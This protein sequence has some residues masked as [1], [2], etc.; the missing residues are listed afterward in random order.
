MNSIKPVTYV[1][2]K[3]VLKWLY[4]ETRSVLWSHLKK[5]RA[6]KKNFKESLN[7]KHTL[8]NY[9][10]TKCNLMF[11]VIQIST[12]WISFLFDILAKFSNVKIISFLL[13]TFRSATDQLIGMT[14]IKLRSKRDLCSLVILDWSLGVLYFALNLN[15]KVASHA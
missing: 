7:K 4:T 5:T 14:E 3:N 15:L 8:D 2:H 9:I 6:W 10:S 12:H 11:L 13:K 1:W